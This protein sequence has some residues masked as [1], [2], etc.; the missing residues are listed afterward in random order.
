ML[1]RRVSQRTFLLRPSE[2]TNR[3]VGYVLTVMHKKWDIAIHAFDV[4]S[5]HWHVV[6]SDPKG[7]VVRFQQ[8][9]H[10]FIARALNASHGEFEAV[11][12]SDQGSRVEAEAPADLLGQIAYTMANP[13]QDGLVRYGKNWP[14]LRMAWPAKPRRFERPPKFFRG[15]D[16]GGA[17]PSCATLEMTRPP[18][19]EH[20]CD[21]ELAATIEEA[22]FAAEEKAR[23]ERD[24][25]GRGFL[26]RARI[27]KQS[28]HDRPRRREP[29]FGISPK[30]A[31]KDKWRRIERLRASKDWLADYARALEEW[32]AG[33]RDAR[34]P[35]GTYKMRILHG[36]RWATTH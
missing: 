23:R 15:K 27:L 33:N 28:R 2:K 5:N 7:N 9:C 11:W 12:S 8:D 18:G 26:G 10:S 19:Y 6:L 29:R 31:C 24:Q 30:L 34:I 17:W 22:T 36:V 4:L 20:L 21:D 25:A 32:R 35:V 3:I 14:G 16:K 1:T 13:V